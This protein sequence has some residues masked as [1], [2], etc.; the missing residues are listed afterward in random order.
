M[1]ELIYWFLTPKDIRRNP[2]QSFGG[3]LIT[4][5]VHSLTDTQ[6]CEDQF[7][8]LQLM[9]F[10][11][12]FGIIKRA[13]ALQHQHKTKD[14]SY[15]CCFCW[16]QF[17]AHG[18]SSPVHVELWPFPTSSSSSFLTALPLWEQISPPVKPELNLTQTLD[19]SFPQNR[20]NP[21]PP[22][23]RRPQAGVAVPLTPVEIP[24]CLPLESTHFNSTFLPVSKQK[25]PFFLI[26]WF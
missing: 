2:F 5:P 13:Q 7:P 23:A 14:W 17:L 24:L 19:I 9:F 15:K 3:E 4:F 18:C 8:H 6:P 26:F 21:A 20:R 25:W 11:G 22:G 1:L 16:F 10:R 12:W